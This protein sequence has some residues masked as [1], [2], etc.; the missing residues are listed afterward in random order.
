MRALKN[1]LL[2]TSTLAGVAA[3]FTFITPAAAQDAVV[4]APEQATVTAE[5]EELVITGTRIRVQDFVAANPV[6]SIT[7]ETLEREGA[8]NLTSFLQETPALVN[9]VDLQDNADAGNRSRAW[10]AG[11]CHSG[12]SGARSSASTTNVRTRRAGS[13]SVA[14]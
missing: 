12:R 5:V 14:G 6:V 13:P 7:S 8:T 4:V 1:S 9:S 2:A 11:S 10:K 3:L